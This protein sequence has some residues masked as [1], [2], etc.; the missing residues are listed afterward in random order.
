MYVSRLALDHYR[1]WEHLVV[2]L[3]PG[4]NVLHGENGLGK[5]NIVE[6]VEVLST[7]TS[8]RTSSSLPLV[9]RGASKA[10]I[11]ANVTD[12]DTT[13]TYEATIAARGANRARVNSGAS[14]YLR[15][16]VGEVPSVT[17]APDDQRLVSG[18]PATRRNF[19][20]QAGALLVPRY[21]DM[22]QQ[23]TRI[24]R[25]R[26]ALLKQLGAR[27]G[28]F[29]A[30]LSGLEIWTGQFIEAGL[31]LTRVRADVVDRLAGPY[32]SIYARLA[33]G[34]G[35]AGISYAPS[36]AEVLQARQTAS[37]A[38]GEAAGDP[39]P[40]IAAHFQRLYA[41]EVSRGV[42]LIGPQRDDLAVTLDGMP[43]REFASNGEMW[44]MAL[45][46]KMA[47]F[48]VVAADRGA[49]P[50]V[51]LDDVFA[52]LDESRRE[53]ILA[54]AAAQDQVLVTVAAAGD[55]PRIVGGKDG[56]DAH[57]PAVNVIDVARLARG[58]DAP[59]APGAPRGA[60]AR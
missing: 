8:H 58:A 11:R 23:F 41:G 20:D 47:L 38:D 18:D 33:S 16:I 46:L 12:G 10:T 51:I 3:A 28:A 52:Q 26:A 21:A 1:S 48:E 4:V 13:T 27:E 44:T 25:Q 17:F 60:S 59:D 30:A 45:A 34:R 29:D 39:R 54:F 15:D 9:A 31:A 56:D 6:A 49:S 14:R 32:A 43:A 35:E 22:L 50:V 5:T 37:G 7:G 57:G 53:Q 42:N 2:D 36:F 24:A 55:I 19:L 40:A